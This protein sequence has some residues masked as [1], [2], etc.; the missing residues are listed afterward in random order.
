MSLTFREAQAIF[1]LCQT[2]APFVAPPVRAFL[3]ETAGRFDPTRDTDMFEQV[4][5]GQESPARLAV[6]LADAL[7]G[8]VARGTILIDDLTIAGA[9]PGLRAALVHGWHLG[10]QTGIFG[11]MPP[12]LDIAAHDR[13]T[14]PIEAILPSLKKIAR[15]LKEPVLT[16]VAKADYGSEWQDHRHALIEVLEHQDCLFTK[17]Q[18]WTPREVVELTSHIRS[19]AGFVC[20]TALLLLNVCLHGDTQSDFEFRWENLAPDYNALPPSVRGPILAGLRYVYESDMDFLTYHTRTYHPL[21]TQDWLIPH[22]TGPL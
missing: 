21:D 13:L 11:V 15:T 12:P 16:E 19:N 9:P 10:R 17:E 6:L 4:Y 5:L 3:Q 22:V 18:F 1:D 7:Q 8:G 2:A 14:R 20:C